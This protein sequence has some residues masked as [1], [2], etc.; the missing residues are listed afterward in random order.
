MKKG[1]V[2]SFAIISLIP[3]LFKFCIMQIGNW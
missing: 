3:K 1:S 2:F